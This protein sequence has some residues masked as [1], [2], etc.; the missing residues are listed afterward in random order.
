[1]IRCNLGDPDF[2]LATHIRDEVKRQL[3]ADLT[4]CNDP[5]GLLPLRELLSSEACS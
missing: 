1:V 3:D 5:Q 2:P 4:H